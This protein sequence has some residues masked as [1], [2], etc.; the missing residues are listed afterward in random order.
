MKAAY[1]CQATRQLSL[2][3]ALAAGVQYKESS[4]PAGRSAAHIS[5]GRKILWLLLEIRPD[6]NIDRA[7]SIIVLFNRLTI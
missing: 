4:T 3:V 7:A 1:V 2:A 5:H 6:Y